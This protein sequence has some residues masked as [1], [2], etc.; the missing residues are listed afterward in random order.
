MNKAFKYHE[1]LLL[2]E[3]IFCNDPKANEK[4]P[5]VFCQGNFQAGLQ[6]DI[7]LVPLYSVGCNLHYG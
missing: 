7:I 5:L 2:T 6:N 3:L 4:I 1:L